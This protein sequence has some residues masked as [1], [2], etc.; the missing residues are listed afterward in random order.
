MLRRVIREP[1]IH[2]LIAGV[3]IFAVYDAFD[4]DAI[5]SSPN[6]I[7]I[8][9]AEMQFLRTQ[10]EKLWGRPPA[11]QDLAPLVREFIREEV[12]YREGVAM[13]LDQ[14]DIIVRRRIGQ[15]MEFLIGDMAVPAEPD[16][17]TLAQYLDAN[18]DKYLEP[19]HLTFTQVYFSVDR[20]GAQARTDAA[21]ALNE[22]GDR[23]RAP[24]LGDRFALSTDYADKT[25]REVDQTFGATFGEQLVAAPVGEWFGPVESAYGVHLVRILVR[26]EPRLPEFAELRDRL[27]ND[28]SFETRQAA[29]EEAL[30][31]LTGRYQI[32]YEGSWPP[33]RAEVTNPA[34]AQVRDSPEPVAEQRRDSALAGN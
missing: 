25:V 33:P 29:N 19:P 7:V 4:E 26:T 24:E 23:Q 2:F 17:A 10:F 27:S 15:K 31:L 3:L 14:D 6:A 16:D 5:E 1:L 28:Y 34:A 22:L 21:A 11:D 8:G 30:E 32:V 9:D 18:R 20:R 13:G 12:L